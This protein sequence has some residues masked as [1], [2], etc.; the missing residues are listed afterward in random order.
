MN[1]NN[2]ESY[3]DKKI[4]ARGYDY[5]EKGYI[6]RINQTEGHVYVAEVEGTD[7]YTVEVE[8]DHDL[9]IV[10][11]LCDCPYDLGEYC[12]HQVAVFLALREM[13]LGIS[14]KKSVS[15]KKTI[16]EKSVIKPSKARDKSQPDM[17]QILLERS[18][19]ELVEFLLKISAVNDEMKQRILLQFND[20][21]DEEEISEAISLIRTSIKMHS[22]RHGFVSYD[23]TNQAVRGAEL[24]LEKAYSV[25]KDKPIYGIN[26]AVCVVREMVGLIENADDSDGTVGCI[27]DQGFRAVNEM[28]EAAEWPPADQYRIFESLLRE[29]AHRRYNGWTDWRLNFLETCSRIADTPAMRT[30][31]EKHIEIL[32]RQEEPGS[33]DHGYYTEKVN[34]IKYNL[35]LNHDGKK[36]AEAFAETQLQFPSFR[37]MAIA[38]SM[39]NRDYERVIK[40]ALDGEM[41]DQSHRG[42]V[43]DWK[44]YRYNAYKLSGKLDEQRELAMEFIMDGRIE[45]Y[46]ELKNT[47]DAKA[48]MAEYPKILF[49]LETQNRTDAAIYTCILIEEGEKGKLLEYV[50]INPSSIERFYKE[51]IPEYKEEVYFLFLEHILRAASRADNRRAYQGVCAIIRNLKKAGGKCQAEEIKQKLNARYANRP[52][53]RDELTRV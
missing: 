42:L 38:Q 34:L 16:S 8:L 50:Q 5:Y 30:Q 11:T 19:E 45:Y 20:A 22:D 41:N 48:W 46:K 18:K 24:V 3:V 36:K 12:K 47:F 17:K 21:D 39:E 27:I 1:L 2:F 14:K 35:I 26:L 15:G 43:M 37:K 10:E 31:L 25:C 29:A 6:K 51:L 23:E 44:K 28:I 13:N 4:F 32:G 49:L 9:N 52:A 33:W 40:L 53:F 7:T